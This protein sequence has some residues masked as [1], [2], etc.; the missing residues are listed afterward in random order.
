MKTLITVL[1]AIPVTIA[2]LIYHVFSWGFVGYNFYNWFILSQ[3]EGA[4]ALSMLQISGVYLFL[5]AI[6]HRDR[7]VFVDEVKDTTTTAIHSIINPWMML[8]FGWLV[9]FFLF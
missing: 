1:V 9:E 3:I 5:A 2:L 6:T 8:V 7:E 4:P